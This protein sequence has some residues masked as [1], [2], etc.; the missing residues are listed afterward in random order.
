MTAHS[1]I[2]Y[3]RIDRDAYM[4]VDPRPLPALF[5][6]LPELR[7]TVTSVLEPFCGAGHMAHDIEME[8]KVCF[9]ADIHDYGYERQT[10]ITDFLET[11]MMPIGA[12][13][14]ISNPPFAQDKIVKHVM[15]AMSLV[16]DGGVVAFLLNHRFDA[17]GSR[18]GLFTRENGF[19]ARVI[20]P[21]RIWW[22]P[23][24]PGSQT[25]A[26]DHTWF[27]WVKGWR[28]TSKN[29][30]L[31]PKMFPNFTRD[32]VRQLDKYLKT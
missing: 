2:K 28:M 9:A 5:M 20:L 7:S 30:Y 19:Y 31:D 26:Q 23:P 8:G 18:S 27:V 21:F 15:H 11:K 10:W 14:I 3:K 6:G 25:P 32:K 17:A 29:I 12:N 4:T 22:F 13:S 24:E 1:T 16:P